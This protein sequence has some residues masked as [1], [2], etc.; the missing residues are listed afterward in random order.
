MS[1][2][3]QAVPAQRGTGP[4]I[5]LLT[6]FGNSDWYVGTLKGVLLGHCPEARLVDLS[7]DLP[8]HDLWAAS[9]ALWSVYDFFPENTIFLAVVD[10]GVGTPRTP[11]CVNSGRHRF[12]CPDNGLLTLPERKAEQWR[13]HHIANENWRLPDLS[14]TFHGRDLF[15]VAAARLALGADVADA[16]PKCA[17]SRRLPFPPARVSTESEPTVHSSAFYADRFGNLF[18]ALLPDDLPDG[19]GSPEQW[20]LRVGGRLIE[21]GLA[22]TFG[23]RRAGELLF[24]WGSSGFMEIAVNQGSAAALLQYTAGM[25]IELYCG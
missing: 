6:D 14:A 25:P 4:I 19:A 10:P 16:G 13:V 7:H 11:I 17:G 9:L 21:G 2:R 3:A 5:A 15:S 12:V 23:D 20:R 1:G 8:R 18:V 22:R 24:Y